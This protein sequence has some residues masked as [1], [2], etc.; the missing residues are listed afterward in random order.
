V[1]IIVDSTIFFQNYLVQKHL[2]FRRS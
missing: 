2:C 1:K